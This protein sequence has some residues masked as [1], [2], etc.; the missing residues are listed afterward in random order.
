MTRDPLQP[1]HARAKLQESLDRGAGLCLLVGAGLTINATG[2][3]RN[4]W[5]ELI[6]QGADAAA[7]YRDQ[8]WVDRVK[9]DVDTGQTADMLAAAEKVTSALGDWY[10][11]WLRETVGSVVPV[12]F[13]LLDEIKRLAAHKKVIPVTTNYDGILHRYLNFERVTW[14]Q[15]KSILMDAFARWLD[16]VIHIHGYWIDRETVVFGSAS[17][18]ALQAQ[19]VALEALKTVLMA[20]T[21]LTVGIGAGLTD[22]TFQVLL[23]WAGQVLDETR[24]IYYLHKDGDEVPEHSHV[25]PVPLSSHDEVATFLRKLQVQPASPIRGS[26]LTSDRAF[27]A[28]SLQSVR[29]CAASPR[30][31]RTNLRARKFISVYGDQVDSILDG[32]VAPAARAQA[33]TARLMATWRTLERT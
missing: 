13:G 24:A 11:R 12:H 27:S 30:T 26:S 16:A 33:W 4:S 14:R 18:Q 8:G 32:S 31:N 21:V 23:G 6:K 19:G 28:S 15:D 7:P 20:N 5:P 3:P 29:D 1:D 2:D 9:A 25:I 17:Y 10:P 22:P